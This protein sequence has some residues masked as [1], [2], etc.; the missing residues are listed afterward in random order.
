MQQVAQTRPVINV[1]GVNSSSVDGVGYD[2]ATQTLQVNFKGK[3]GPKSYQYDKVPPD[4]VTELHKAESIGSFVNKHVVRG[5][6]KTHKLEQP[7]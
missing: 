7:K 1:L 4:L 2:A 3:D 6:F 5:G